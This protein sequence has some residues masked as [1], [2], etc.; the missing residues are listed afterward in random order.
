MNMEFG[1]VF[2]NTKKAELVASSKPGDTDKGAGAHI[3]DQNRWAT[4]VKEKENK[5]NKTE[6]VYPFKTQESHHKNLL[7]RII[8]AKG[9]LSDILNRKPLVKSDRE[10]ASAK[11]DVIKSFEKDLEDYEKRQQN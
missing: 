2:G 10:E 5:V 4:K 7:E 3:V 11:R 9:E 6:K 8:I 1:N